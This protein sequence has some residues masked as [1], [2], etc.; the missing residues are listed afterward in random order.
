MRSTSNKR[1]IAELDIIEIKN[2]CASNDPIEKVKIQQ[3]NRRK[4]LQI[5]YLVRVLHP[6]YTNNS[7]S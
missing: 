1:E 3:Q 4:S 6:I 2:F 5:T 7:Y